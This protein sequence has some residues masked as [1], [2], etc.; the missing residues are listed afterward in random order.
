MAQ[1]GDW[2]S[3]G[4]DPGGSQYS[5]LGQLTRD[6]VARLRPAWEHRSGDVIDAPGLAGT[7]AEVTALHVN[8]RLYYC[9]S[10][11]KVFALDPA[12]GEELWRFDGHAA[13][14]DV[15]RLPGACRG[16]AYWAAATPQ[17]DQ[18]CQRR[19]FKGDMAGRLWAL[20][21]DSGEPCSD[22][23][24]AAGRG[25]YVNTAGFDNHGEGWWA[26]T[27]PPIVIG[28]RL[29]AGAAL[30]DTVANAKDGAVRAFDVRSGELL[31]TFN[32]V[33][34][35]ISAITGGANA[36]STL[37][38]DPVRGL[39]FVP[40]TSLS[41]DYYG[42]QRGAGSPYAD[43]VAALDV[44]TGQPRWHFQIIRHDLFDYDLPGHPLLVSIRKGGQRKDVAIQVAKTGD[45]FVLDRDTG[46]P[47]FPVTEMAAPLS[48]LS[49]ETSAP[50]QPRSSVA[51]AARQI[52][53]EED[54]FGLTAFDR[55][56]CRNAFAAARYDGLFTPPSEQGSLIFPSIRGGP[57]WGAAAYH[58]G[59]NLLLVRADALATYVQLF[60]PEDPDSEPVLTDYMNRSLPL[61]G[62]PWWV[63]VRPF[64]SPLG[65][66]C[67]GPPW[68]TLTAIDMDTGK[69]RWRV[70]LGQAR[71][72]GIDVPEETGWGSPG[73][74][75]PLVTAGGLV[76]IAA[77]LDHH[78]RALDVS[79]GK[80]LWKH[81]L[82]APGMAVPMS[83]RAGGRQFVVIAA[84]GNALAGT[85]VSDAI[86]AF[87]LPGD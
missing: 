61:R 74:G 85:T 59:E 29:V 20:D 79:T 86:V 50:E 2:P 19:I 42:G 11:N 32:P 23:G 36:W 22:F 49:G 48:D 70:P 66:P 13:S 63:R 68:G 67:T 7:N 18:P 53:G 3:F 73:V 52:L 71:R 17:A 43:A 83:Y 38:A 4:N 35:A 30:E 31:W 72:M 75:G 25:G 34:E 76:F 55:Q 40:F 77:S 39:V 87:A 57:G 58:P 84:G 44:A 47:V 78:I 62:T 15:E 10:L 60:Q 37:S 65:L 45:V 33:P 41:T 24:A 14:G 27:S 54:L 81:S 5:P 69:Q 12:T 16:L 9:T 56:W 8:N 28:N 46:Q 1:A 21:A 80:Q 6:N 26:M 51:P 64:L 82:P